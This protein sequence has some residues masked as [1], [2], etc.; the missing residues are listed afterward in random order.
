MLRRIEDL[1]Q[2]SAGRDICDKCFLEVGQMSATSPPFSDDAGMTPAPRARACATAF[3]TTGDQDAAWSRPAVAVA[4][5][6]RSHEPQF[7][8]LL[9]A[10]RVF[11]PRG[12]HG[13]G[14]GVINLDV[15]RRSWRRIPC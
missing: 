9:R 15:A 11:R 1:D 7:E 5:V 6:D 12:C 13:R 2:R 14:S 8:L 10:R 3:V 4:A